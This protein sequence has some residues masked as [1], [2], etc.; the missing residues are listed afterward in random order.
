MPLIAADGALRELCATAGRAAPRSAR[1]P[2]PPP[3]PYPPVISSS[4]ATVLANRRSV[5][6]FADR[7]VPAALLAVACRAGILVE[8]ACWPPGLHGDAGIGVAIAAARVQSLAPGVYTFSAGGDGFRYLGG[9]SLLGELQRA[10]ANAPSLVL[11]YGTLGRAGGAAPAPSYQSMLVRAAALGHA[12][13]L[14][15]MT[16]GLRGCPFGRT[17]GQISQLVNT[18]RTERVQQLFAVALGWL[19][20]AEPPQPPQQGTN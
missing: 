3:P 15:A 8:R 1:H 13:L 6:Q 19:P 18:A 10:Y 20:E 14:N 16:A 17:A 9:R 11:V 12:A 7:P 2:G 5:R 4:L